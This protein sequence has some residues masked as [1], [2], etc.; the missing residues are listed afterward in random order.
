MKKKLFGALL[1]PILALGMLFTSCGGGDDG[2]THDVQLFAS[3]FVEV[4]PGS[5]SWALEL[6]FSRPIALRDSEVRLEGTRVSIVYVYN[7]EGERVPTELVEIVNIPLVGIVHDNVLGPAYRLSL[8][9]NVEAIPEPLDE[10]RGG[11]GYEHGWSQFLVTISDVPGYNISYAV[12]SR[13]PTARAHNAPSNWVAFFRP[14]SEGG[15]GLRGTWI[16]ATGTEPGALTPAE[17]LVEMFRDSDPANPSPDPSPQYRN[18][19][20][21]FTDTQAQDLLRDLHGLPAGT[22]LTDQ[23]RKRINVAAGIIHNEAAISGMTNPRLGMRILVGGVPAVDGQV[24]L[25]HNWREPGVLVPSQ[26]SP[27]Y[28]IGFRFI[29][30]KD[31][32]SSFNGGIPFTTPLWPITPDPFNVDV[33]RAPGVSGAITVEFV[34]F[35]LPSGVASNAVKG[36]LIR[37]AFTAAL[38]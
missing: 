18:F 21:W 15:G 23:R 17:Q 12:R 16:G 8:H 20:G 22:S 4:N 11:H 30:V 38:P 27:N 24:K 33:W 5:V 1:V 6:S 28:G 37:D 3:R 26:L 19:F 32:W 29:G 35:E 10:T 14:Q 25:V 34:A 36:A 13:N 31:M 2:V 7:A 9:Q